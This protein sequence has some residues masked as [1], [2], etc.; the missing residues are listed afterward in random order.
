MLDLES[1]SSKCITG[2]SYTRHFAG[3][4]RQGFEMQLVL[5]L[6]IQTQDFIF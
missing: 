4:E 3:L 2:T 5:K 1:A 6:E